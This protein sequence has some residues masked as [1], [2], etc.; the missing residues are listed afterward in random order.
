MVKRNSALFR[1]AVYKSKPKFIV[2]FSAILIL[3]HVSL[4][5]GAFFDTAGQSARPMGMG[6]VFIASTGTASSYW[7]NPAG[8]AS[9]DGKK[10]GISYGI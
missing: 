9:L 1:K 6:E 7:Y 8:L 3:I 4:A 10:L 2:A 5:Y